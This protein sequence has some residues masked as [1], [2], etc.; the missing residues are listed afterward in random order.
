MIFDVDVA[1]SFWKHFIGLSF[2]KKRNMLFEM[3]YDG[4]WNLW[5]FGVNYPLTMIFLS[6]DKEVVDVQTAKP[7]SFNPKTWRS[8]SS[9]EP[10]RYIL[11]TPY[12]Y[13]LKIGN[14]LTW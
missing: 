3:S 7:L 10:C 14:Q 1:D 8:Y 11:E 12:S 9:K 2:S 6:K 4:T 5:M 13:G